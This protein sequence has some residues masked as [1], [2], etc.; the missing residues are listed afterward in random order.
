MAACG[1]QI[2]SPKTSAPKEAIKSAKYV[3]VPPYTLDFNLVKPSVRIIPGPIVAWKVTVKLTGSLTAV[4]DLLLGSGITLKS[5]AIEVEKAALGFVSGIEVNKV[6]ETEMKLGTKVGGVTWG[7]KLKPARPG[8]M[9]G[10]A[11]GQNVKFK[12]GRTV[13]SGKVGVEVTIQAIPRVKVQDI[14]GQLH[15]FWLDHGELI[16]GVA[17]I[18]AGVTLAVIAAPTI[19]TPV[20]GDEVVAYAAALRMMTGG[21]QLLRFA[22]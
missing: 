14:K 18:G 17:L 11:S 15:E 1:V 13:F 19:L 8:T 20:P 10:F 3:C 5:T 2:V 7:I 21:M 16:K 9:T 22:P 4:C 6:G 12:S